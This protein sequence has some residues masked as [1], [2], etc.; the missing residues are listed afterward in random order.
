MTNP[1]RT[2]T[3]IELTK[4]HVGQTVNL[5]GWIFRRRDHGG[6]VFIDLRDNEGITQVVF[7][8]DHAGNEMIDRVTHLSLESVIQISGQVVAREKDQINPSMATGEIE[9][10]VAELTVHSEIEQIPYNISD[11]TV[12]AVRHV[13]SCQRR[14]AIHA[15]PSDG[16][17]TLRCRRSTEC[18]ASELIAVSGYPG[19]MW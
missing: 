6:V 19:R 14:C 18:S 5:A 10:D 13:P 7:H 9:V 2:H 17:T 12:P 16:R 11:E 8:P 15:D 4:E 1:Y 3:C